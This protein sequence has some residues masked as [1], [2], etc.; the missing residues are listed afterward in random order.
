MQNGNAQAHEVGGLAAENQKQIW[1]SSTWINHTIKIV[2]VHCHITQRTKIKLEP[3][4]PQHTTVS[5][6]ISMLCSIEVERAKQN[7]WPWSHQQKLLSC[8]CRCLVETILQT[9]LRS[10]EC[11]SHFL[12]IDCYLQGLPLLDFSSFLWF[13]KFH[14][15]KVNNVS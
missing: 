2:I 8:V 10:K 6:Q 12:S 1:T 15:P 3:W 13:L 11:Q 14:L 5:Y 9:H 4:I 7:V